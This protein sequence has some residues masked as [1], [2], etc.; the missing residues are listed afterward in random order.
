MSG[1]MLHR[2][3]SCVRRMRG[4]LAAAVLLPLLLAFA[5][6]GRPDA[7]VQRARLALEKRLTAAVLVA[8]VVPGL[9][10]ATY[11]AAGLLGVSLPRFTALVCVAVTIWTAGLFWLAAVWG[12]TLGDALQRVTGL[13]PT[14]AVVLAVLPLAVFAIATPRLLRG[15]STSRSSDTGV[16]P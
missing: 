5:L 11:T 3:L 12:Q 6:L 10:F 7:P 4:A 9:R 15:F 8:R 13:D 2:L 16:A 14:T 1:T